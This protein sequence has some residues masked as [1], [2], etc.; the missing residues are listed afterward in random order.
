[1]NAAGRWALGAWLAVGVAH[2]EPAWVHT[3]AVDAHGPPDTPCAP[4]GA[5]RS[6]GVASTGTSATEST[7]ID[8]GRMATFV[9]DAA[10]PQPQLAPEDRERLQIGQ[11]YDLTRVP[12]EPLRGEPDAVARVRAVYARMAAR[13]GVVRVAFWGASHVAGEYFTGAV[14]RTLQSRF[15][16]A[17][18]GFVLPAAPWSGYRASDTNLCTQG[19]W[20]SDYD[21]RS[22][23]RGDGLLGVGGISV[24]ASSPDSLGWVQTA[25][26]NPQGRSVA[27]FEVQYLLQP[28][29]GDVDLI[30]DDAAPVRASTAGSGPGMTI[31]TVPRGPHRLT[32]RPAGNG[33]V[34]LFGV[35]LEDDGPGVVV[36]A[37]GVTGR[38]MSS[39]TRWNAD[40][41]RAYLQRRMP[42][43]AVLAYGTNEANDPRLNPESYRA[44]LRASLTRMRA[45]LPDAACVL[46]GPSDRGKKL[47]GSTWAIW[48]PTAFVAR[49]QAEVGPAFGCATWD[50]QQVTGGP[51]SMMRW[52]LLDPP[53]AA[54]DGIHFMA[55]GYAEIGDRFVRAWQGP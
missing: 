1:M 27:R 45:V 16:D 39:W 17:G 36:D 42:D 21:R 35:N 33:P 41:Q 19:A 54:A 48:S 49:V 28:G 51:G 8:T 31:L 29:G 46:I 53:M 13:S 52:R 30:V 3:V 24:E 34:R 55:S 10:S 12:L 50:L 2:A 23:G 5:A 22:G 32:V 9:L 6:P 43:L 47:G 37:M 40:L 4:S 25:R 14:R 11:P 38:T 20:I 18:H 15:G 7:P 44:E 26:T